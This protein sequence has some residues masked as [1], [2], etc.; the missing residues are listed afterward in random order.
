VEW[1][2]QFCAIVSCLKAIHCNVWLEIRVWCQDLW[3]YLSR[4]KP[5][6]GGH[7]H[8]G[9]CRACSAGTFVRFTNVHLTAEFGLTCSVYIV[10][11][12]HER[13][14]AP[15]TPQK[16]SHDPEAEQVGIM[17]HSSDAMFA[18]GGQVDPFYD[19][20]HSFAD[21]QRGTTNTFLAR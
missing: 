5:Y 20:R 17:S 2:A 6:N 1:D 12:V 9:P 7:R 4:S 11:H 18:F 19:P 10:V 21:S 8:S 15:G 3:R 13:L 16:A 14:A